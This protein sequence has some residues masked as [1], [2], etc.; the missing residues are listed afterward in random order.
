M[1]EVQLASQFS[2]FP[3][4]ITAISFNRDF[5]ILSRL[6]AQRD[7]LARLLES[8]ETHYIRKTVISA[9]KQ[10]RKPI[11]S[12]DLVRPH[13]PLRNLG[14]LLAWLEQEK[15]DAIIYYRKELRRVTEQIEKKRSAPED[16]LR[17]P[18]AF[19]T[20]EDPLAA[21]MACQ[22]VLHTCPGYMTPRTLP[23]S[24]ED[25]V[26]D[27][28]CMTWWERNVRTVASNVAIAALAMLCVVPVALIGL[29]SQ[30]I[31]LT[32]ALESLIWVDRLP[33]WSLGFIQ[34]VL[35]PVLLAALVKAFSATLQQLVCKQ[36]ITSKSIISLRVQDFYF[37]F[38]FLQTTLVVSLSA[39]LTSIVNEIASGQSMPATLA[40]NLP[41]A[42]N[43]FLSYVL[44][45]AL[46][47]SANSLLRIDRLIARLLL[48][49]LFDKT[50]TQKLVRQK[51]TDI[52]WG[53]FLPVY[54]NLACIGLSTRS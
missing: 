35:P 45:Q 26:W 41:K 20:F 29:L 24:V 47:A 4:K 11:V 25:V 19:I 22:T 1:D 42:S 5:R 51:G 31:Y 52:E 15:V 54:T 46:S 38:L 13:I 7:A 9:R 16:F 37:C 21:H 14:S 44:L 33:E 17:L 43:Y 23:I 8:A 49:P 34:G 27:N 36:G 48:A 6:V 50:V 53:I 18:S 10:G 28:V 12:R 40:K 32:R 39:G 2:V 30:V 3:G